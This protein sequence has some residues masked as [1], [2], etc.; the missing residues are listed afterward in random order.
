MG[1]FKPFAA[2]LSLLMLAGCQSAVMSDQTI[3][4]NEA[5]AD[6]TNQFF[7]L[8]VL[9]ARDRFPLYYTRSTGNSA[10]G[11]AGG[12]I[13]TDIEN[14]HFL[15]TIGATAGGGNAVSLANLDDQKFMRGVLTPVP[16]STLGFYVDQGW[17]KEVVM[18]M[19]I[20]SMEI[21]RDLVGEM[22][23]RFDD[24]CDLG[25][26]T[27]YCDTRRP[28]GADG[29][30]MPRP[31]A[32]LRNRC[33]EGSDK[34]VTFHN[35]PSDADGSL[36]FRA[37]LRV[38]ISLGLGVSTRD[39][40][41]VVVPNLPPASA[42]NLEGLSNAAAAKL[43]V[44][45]R[46]D[47]DFAVCSKDEVSS[48]TLDPD[49]F[50]AG[51][52]TAGG[53]FDRPNLATTSLSSNLPTSCAAAASPAPAAAGAE[54]PVFSFTTRSLD[55]MLYYLGEDLRA[56]DSVTI[57]TGHHAPR[58]AE[59]P[60]FMVERGSSHELV[61]ID[62]RGSHYAIPDQC[63]DDMTCEQ[64]HRSLQVL[65]LLNQIWGLQKEASEAPTVPVV[66]VINR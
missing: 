14:W 55:S 37:M 23:A 57:W 9:R 18:Q 30:P 13:S 50:A 39:E 40:Y 33:L 58:L 51:V 28:L 47:G 45:R 31:S 17:P 66:S 22:A 63:G 49:A 43:V 52:A 25:R 32:Y 10:S 3:A 6:S 48:F 65:S 1:A 59:I 54:P 2:V 42:H 29:E 35:D 24:R 11:S 7:L 46:K 8:N 5:V 26:H 27:G 16:L 61:G 44:A 4:Y 62:Y 38:L 20:N 53:F 60:L 56:G 21:D 64:Q 36:C 19:F 12:A 41:T 15:P 34:T